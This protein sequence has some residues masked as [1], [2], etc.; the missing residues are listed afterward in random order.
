MQIK[1]Y[2][3][4]SVQEHVALISKDS[5]KA[6]IPIQLQNPNKLDYQGFYFVFQANN[7]PEE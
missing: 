4:R 2:G 1:L 7:I 5:A 3:F 6:G